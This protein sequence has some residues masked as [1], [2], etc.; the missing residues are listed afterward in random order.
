MLQVNL[1]PHEVK[2]INGRRLRR[3]RKGLSPTHRALL[4]YELEA[5]GASIHDLT[6]HDACALTGASRSY[7]ATVFRASDEEREQVKSGQLALAVLHN[8][9]PSDSYLD[10]LILK[11]G[12]DR[13]MAALDRY[14]RPQFKFA[15]E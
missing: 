13:V 5:G 1:S 6:R 14:T 2:N 12:A 10:R 7:V 4:A 8:K 3:R 11:V 15:A 9:P